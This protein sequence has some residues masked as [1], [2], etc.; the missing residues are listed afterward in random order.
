[1]ISAYLFVLIFGSGLGS[2]S[3]KLVQPERFFPVLA[4]MGKY[5]NTTGKLDNYINAET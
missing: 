4:F 5:G 2:V 3:E 1:M